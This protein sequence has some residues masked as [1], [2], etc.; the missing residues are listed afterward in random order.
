MFCVWKEDSMKELLS[1]LVILLWASPSFAEIT[2]DSNGRW[3]TS[4]DCPEWQMCA[5]WP[6]GCPLSCDGLIPGGGWGTSG[7]HYEQITSEANNPLGTGRG[8]RHWLADANNGNSG[9]LEIVF[10]SAL[11]EFWIRF[12]IRFPLGFSWASPLQYYKIIYINRGQTP[13]LEVDW[14]WGWT[15][16]GITATTGGVFQ[17]LM[18]DVNS[19]WETLM[20]NS[21]VDARTGKHQGDGKWHCFECHFKTNTSGANGIWELWIDGIRKVNHANVDY[22]G[23]LFSRVLIGSNHTPCLNGKDTPVDYDDIVVSTKAYIGPMQAT[24][25]PPSPPPRFAPPTQPPATKSSMTGTIDTASGTSR[26][27]IR[28][29]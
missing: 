12:Y 11:P 19:G 13:Y 15:R 29:K 14:P 6:S 10:P 1:V 21:T 7:G 22:R 27:T 2:F 28:P 20:A 24:P 17:E 16:S 5:N 18:G 4:F 23:V 8:Q 26:A 9:G 25:P 3:S